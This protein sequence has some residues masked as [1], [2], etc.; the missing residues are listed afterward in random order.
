M[1]EPGAT[2][3]QEHKDGYH[4]RI[5]SVMSDIKNP[6]PGKP[7]RVS[8]T[9]SLGAARPADKTAEANADRRPS[10]AVF[11]ALDL[12]TNNCRLLVA[13]P[14]GGGF[15][16]IDAFSRIVR[17]GEGLSRT[18][19]LSDAAMDRAVDALKVCAHKIDRRRVTCLRSVAT[20]ACRIADNADRFIARVYDETGLRLDVISAGEEA[21]LA[22]LGCQSLLVD[23]LSDALVFDI[24]GGSTELIHVRRTSGGYRIMAWISMPWGVINLAERYDVRH[25][26]EAL[27]R[28]MVD[29]M[30]RALQ[31][32][33]R[34]HGLDE[35]V[36]RGAV[37]LLGTSGTVTTLGSVYLQLPAYDRAKV[38]GLWI[39]SGDVRDLTWSVA[40]MS[41]DQRRAQPCIGDDRADLVV[42]GCAIL[43][44]ILSLWP[45]ER[46]RVADRGIR[47]G[48]LRGLM[49]Q[50][51]EVIMP[52]SV[53]ATL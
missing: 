49:E 27:F 43:E 22:V 28:T 38:D 29:E 17:L 45:A 4:N 13:R 18:G 5:V 21:R 15:R 6:G 44:A 39:D 46:L 25:A 11:S 14:Q 35:V 1:P 26:D 3:K 9:D 7:A 42:A 33:G 53:A 48:I 51:P 19:R 52:P 47:E 40:R 32:F 31:A 30:R 34:D 16:I 20:E 41:Y 37:Q 12:G 24:G 50:G 36:A 2:A 23:D 10:R 8:G